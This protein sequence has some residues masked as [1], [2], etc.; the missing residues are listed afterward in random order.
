MRNLTRIKESTRVTHRT[1]RRFLQRYAKEIPL[2]ELEL[3]PRVYGGNVVFYYG[4]DKI[5][6]VAKNG[7]RATLLKEAKISQYLNAQQLPVVFPEPLIVHPK[8]FYVVF[9]RI[10]GPAW[11]T[12]L[13]AEWAPDQ[14]EAAIQALGYFLSYLHQHPFPDQVLQYIPKAPDPFAVQLKRIKRKIQFVED[15]SREFDTKDWEKQ[16]ARLQDSLQQ[17]WAVTHC[18]LSMGHIMA[19]RGNPEQLAVIDF[20]DAHISDPSIDLIE[21]AIELHSDLPEDGLL[22]GQMMELL[23]QHY[24]TDDQAIAEKLEFGLLEFQIGRAYQQVRRSV[25]QAEKDTLA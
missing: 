8:G 1:A 7:Q 10:D 22:A 5:V 25:R 23:L 14:L 16:L 12:E 9:S 24:Q 18:D 15:H 19:V 20:A 21:L 6:K 3:I 2:E 4:D 11:G 17:I 13:F